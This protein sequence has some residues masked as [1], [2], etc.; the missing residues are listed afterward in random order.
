MYILGHVV[1]II[2][3][4]YISDS[5]FPFIFAPFA[6]VH[7]STFDLRSFSIEHFLFLRPLKKRT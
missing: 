6:P 2:L 5:K 3:Y 4:I 1:L 7:Y